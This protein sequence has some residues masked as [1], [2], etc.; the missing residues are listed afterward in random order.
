MSSEEYPNGEIRVLKASRF[1]WAVLLFTGAVFAFAGVLIFFAAPGGRV[2]GVVVFAFFGLGAVVAAVQLVFRSTLT[3]TPEGFTFT[4]LGRRVTRAW[5][6]IDSFVPVR[7]S[8]LSSMVGIRL[9]VS[10]EQRSR[11]RKAAINIWGYD[12]G[13]IPETYGMRADELAAL[14]NQ[15]R[16]RYGNPRSLGRGGW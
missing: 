1:K 13:A 9:A 8:A 10:A 14:M 6:D 3:M 5:K 12:G 11:L 15:W 7:T 16:D 4:G 2:G